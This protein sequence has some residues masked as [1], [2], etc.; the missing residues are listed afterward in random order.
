MYPSLAMLFAPYWLMPTP[1]PYP[2]VVI[3]IV[4]SFILMVKSVERRDNSLRICVPLYSWLF[5]VML[6][7]LFE[8]SFIMLAID[9]LLH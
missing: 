5:I 9:M 6:D 1:W 7:T 2:F 8:L 4:V 3:S